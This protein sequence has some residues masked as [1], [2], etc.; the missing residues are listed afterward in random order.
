MRNAARVQSNMSTFD[1]VAAH[2]I[3]IDVIYHF[4]AVYIRVIVRRGNTEGVV[5]VESRH[6]RSIGKTSTEELAVMIDT[7]RPLSITT[8]ALGIDD[9][10][11]YKSWL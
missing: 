7:F 10:K 9:G 2:K 11:Y 5:I 8:A 6:E 3:A 1:V 4:V